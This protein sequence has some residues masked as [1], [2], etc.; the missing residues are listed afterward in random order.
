MADFSAE[1]LAF[2]RSVV[3]SLDDGFALY[4]PDDRLLAWNA[5]YESLNTEVR[6][7][8]VE[9][10]SFETLVRA[11][12]E[13]GQ[14]P[15]A[16]GREREWIEERKRARRS[17]LDFERQ[18]SDGRW[19]L[20]RERAAFGNGIVGIWSDIT[21]QKLAEAALRESERRFRDFA[22]ISADI[23]WEMDG[24]LRYSYISGRVADFGLAP[25]SLLGKTRAEIRVAG[26]PVPF[27]DEQARLQAAGAAFRDLER[28]SDVAPG[29]WIRNNAKPLYDEE[30]RLVGYRGA[31]RIIT[32]QKRAEEELRASERRLQTVLENI[33]Q[34][35]SLFDRDLTGALSNR[36]FHELLGL[37]AERFP[38]GTPLE[39][40]VRFNAERGEYGPGDVEALVRER[41]EVAERGELYC[42]ERTR[43]DGTVIEMRR[44][45]LPG[46]GFV[47]TYSDVTERRRSEEAVRQARA[48]LLDAI[49][50]MS[51][52]LALF[53]AEERL[54]L[55]NRHYRALYPGLSAHL[56][57]GARFETLARHVFK[58]MHE[59]GLI[60]S[61]D[62]AVRGRVKEF[63]SCAAGVEYQLAD[64]RWNLCSDYRTRQGGTVSVRTDITKQKTAEIA[65]RRSEARFRD[66]AE[67]SAELLWE[68]DKE[69]RFT[70]ASPTAEDFGVPAASLLGKSR[71]E[72]RPPG[73]VR[74][75]EDEETL[76]VESRSPYRNIE[77]LSDLRDGRWISVS[78]K[79][80]FA[81]DG[82]FLGYR[83]ATRDVTERKLAE[84]RL[85]ESRSILESILN[86][87]PLG[88]TLVERDGRLIF[89]N[90][91]EAG[92][93][94]Y[95]REAAIGRSIYEL[96]PP[97]LAEKARERNRHVVETG[98]SIPFFEE[99]AHSRG[100]WTTML[101]GKIPIKSSADE[102]TGV[103]TM[104]VDIT[105][106]IEAEE[107]QRET[108][109]RL[110]QAQKMEAVGQLTGGVAHDFNN[111]MGIIVGNA[112][113]L[114]DRLGDDEEARHHIKVIKAA[115]D[116]GSSLTERL[117]AFS[118]Q[119]TL[120]PV[121][122]DVSAL[123]AGLEEM[124]RRTLGEAIELS[125]EAAAVVWPAI[126]DPH[127]FEN[128]LLNL[129]INA[130]DSMLQGGALLIETANV[131]LDETYAARTEDLAAG[132][133]VKV[134][135]SDRGAGM[136]AEIL[137]RVFEPF[138]TTKE[139]G[140]GS[141]LGLSMVYGFAKQSGGHV[142]IYSE[143]GHGTTVN[144]YLPRAETAAAQ[145][146]APRPQREPP[147]GSERILV[148][149]DD[150]DLREVP[151]ILLRRHGYQVVQVAD[152]LE[153]IA[154]LEA[155][156][157]FDLLFTDVV[158]PGGMNGVEIAAEA[159][160][161]QPGIKVL[162]TSGYTEN[163]VVHN[164][165]LDSG[166]TL[167]NKPYHS[168]DLL[169][170]VRAILDGA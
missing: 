62:E 36:R 2:L 160:R 9:G 121:S 48:Q 64:G 11:I 161:L 119:Q 124:L 80:L 158:L 128:A 58:A 123:V 3:A 55:C 59:A 56:K 13:R 84:R 141:G 65:L 33:D 23:L 60:D 147:R 14:V 46:G 120:S 154:Q 51:D 86:A 111:L 110:R 31:N 67:V 118:R 91:F 94:G 79:P 61:L 162:Y 93:W 106:R 25:A 159:R 144:L 98:E 50:S 135:V 74:P 41:M 101:I 17:G 133:Y 1:S 73:L 166:V 132:D 42:A 34:G 77:R 63:R 108:M 136:P 95:E 97:D 81:E 153:A 88:V 104:A 107:A 40:Y 164:G 125:V 85:E 156:P 35:V 127:Q 29:E 99:M 7:L 30:G 89:T 169:E 10:V 131:T 122:V 114:E 90:R 83:G 37:P 151:V 113:L 52:G 82:E 105:S 170:K 44:N 8:L 112:E 43:P 145:L 53:D 12:A 100:R 20:V 4:D 28:Q 117:L 16:L 116:R 39:A 19:F 143:V 150:P 26:H 87:L 15:Q 70:F 103:C 140:K 71:Q 24:S 5:A 168:A 146:T 18:V 47:T 163:V 165:Q 22:E 167:V 76:A 134:A 130:R 54:I 152:G 102:V 115:V 149:E 139:T 6:D 109:E 49:E 38:P 66:F 138:F 32:A 126:I 75:D 137:E 142:S 92:R 21:G 57:P 69:L 45:P 78:G 155:G 27:P 68:T 72:I 129:A 148:V 157:A 96:L